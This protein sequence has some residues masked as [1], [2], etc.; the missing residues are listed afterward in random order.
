MPRTFVSPNYFPQPPLFYEWRRRR[1][2]S[3]KERSLLQ[4][5]LSAHCAKHN[6]KIIL[7]LISPL[8]PFSVRPSSLIFNLH[9]LHFLPPSLALCHSRRYNEV[10]PSIVRINLPPTMHSK[11]WLRWRQIL[12]AFSTLAVLAPILDRLGHRGVFLRLLRPELEL[13]LKLFA[14]GVDRSRLRKSFARGPIAAAGHSDIAGRAC[15]AQSP[16]KVCTYNRTWTNVI[17]IF[18]TDAA[19]VC[20]VRT[21][22]RLRTLNNLP[23][24]RGSR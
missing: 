23:S 24:F 11:H 9:L 14:A 1:N 6:G 22:L 10:L 17:K 12:Y 4:G 3:G 13:E 18:W 5:A 8:S 20:I 16:V 21:Y 7:H 15:V 19:V 2:W